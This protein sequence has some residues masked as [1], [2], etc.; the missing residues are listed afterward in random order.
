MAC[1]NTDGTI[2]TMAQALLRSLES[3]RSPEE[4]A[5]QAGVPLFRVRA[6]LRELAGAGLIEEDSGRYRITEAGRSKI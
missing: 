2:S 5:A 6:S 4:A 3:P 1:I